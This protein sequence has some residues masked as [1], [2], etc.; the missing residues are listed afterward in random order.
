MANLYHATSTTY[1]QDLLQINSDTYILAYGGYDAQTGHGQHIKTFKVKP[2][3][4]S[5]VEIG[6]LVHDTYYSVQNEVSM[7]RVDHDTYAIAYYGYNQPTD[8]AWGG[9]IK[10][11][12]VNGGTITE[13]A[14]YKHFTST[15]YDNS[16][17]KVDGNTFALA[18]SDNQYDGPVSYTHLTLP[19]LYSV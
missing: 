10:T 16:F 11:F 6:D 1:Q 14:K 15:V 13:V 9:Y 8:N 7:I 12:T 18:W 19:T 5:I 17:I 2:D 4:T 3:G